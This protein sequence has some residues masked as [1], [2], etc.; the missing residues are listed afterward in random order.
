MQK[1]TC[2]L[3]VAA[4]LLLAGLTVDAKAFSNASVDSVASAMSTFSYSRSNGR[5][6]Q[7]ASQMASSKNGNCLDMALYFTDSLD[8]LGLSVEIVGESYKDS[9]GIHKAPNDG[10]FIGI[11]TDGKHA[12]ASSNNVIVEFNTVDAAV[13]SGGLP[14][15]TQ[16]LDQEILPGTYNGLMEQLP[17]IVW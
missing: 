1:V 6:T 8:D 3:F 16:I 5:P 15:G 7:T 12:W 17:K 2:T 11:A 9:S 13:A 10:H 14:A 4:M